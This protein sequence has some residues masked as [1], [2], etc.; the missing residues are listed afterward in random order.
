[1]SKLPA[2][3]LEHG[4]HRSNRRLIPSW[5]LAGIAVAI[6]ALFWIST[7]TAAL[8]LDAV[9]Q[10]VNASEATAAELAISA[11]LDNSRVD[12]VVVFRRGA[13]GRDAYE[14]HA[15]RPGGDAFVRYTRAS[16]GAGFAYTI[17][18]TSGPDLIARD[19]P[20][21]LATLA[22][23]RAAAGADGVIEP[24]NQFYPYL[25]E[26]ASL[27]FDDPNAGDLFYFE[28]P[29][30]GSG[31]THGSMDVTQSRAPLVLS[32]AG[33]KKAPEGSAHLADDLVRSVD[34]SPTLA[35]LLGVQK[36]SGRTL[37]GE[38]SDS[39]FLLQQDGGVL[40][41]RI[42]GEGQAARSVIIIS[43]G[44][45]ATLMAGLLQEGKMP[46]VAALAANGVMLRYGT[47]VGFPS[48]TY[49]NH[50]TV[51][52]GAFPTHHGLIGNHYYLRSSRELVNP[53][54]DFIKT[55]HYLATD[56]ETLF[57]AVHRTFGI[58]HITN[59]R[60][61]AYTAS[62]ND[63]CSRGAIYATTELR[64][65]NVTQRVAPI[66]PD[67]ATTPDGKI[68]AARLADDA[69]IF[70]LKAIFNSFLHPKPKHVQI[71]LGLTDVAGHAL[72]PWSPELPVYYQEAD[73]R[74]GKIVDVIKSAG[75]LDETAIVFTADHGME[76][77]GK[78]YDPRSPEQSMRDAGVQFVANGGNV[79]LQ[80]LHLG[81]AGGEELTVGEPALVG[82]SVEEDDADELG[83]RPPVAGAE[84]NL[85]NG[86]EASQ[87]STDASGLASLS[88]TPAAEEIAISATMPAF[89]AA[90]A[91]VEV[92][93]EP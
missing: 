10:G 87:A 1:M 49:P 42:T 59:N 82:V 78:N 91:T 72:G 47:I 79:Y 18:E 43:D 84:V 24:E 67:A 55:E 76:Q 83:A 3:A 41:D 92:R 77:L 48:V 65:G 11:L 52:S 19:D 8:P 31:G 70:Q 44:M 69:A 34:I 66:N 75:V 68:S 46:N 20:R 35:A 22:E 61:G 89:N 33:F 62:I 29:G 54:E 40:A 7:S 58:H 14:I 30:Q 36:R 4:L 80:S 2:F 60:S 21:G 37:N 27:V 90:T 32:G 71:N 39:V 9:D 25:L 74:I 73:E 64:F 38:S 88:F 53:I 23:E 63:P 86:S 56:V 12:M 50:N 57:E 15:R 93:S 28:K 13:D 51:G 26:R 6:G 5:F 81:I 85:T 16:Q 17:L 45:S